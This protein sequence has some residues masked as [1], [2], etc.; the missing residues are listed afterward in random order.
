MNNMNKI[1]PKYIDVP[2]ICF[3]L[4]NKDNERDIEFAKQRMVRGFDDSETWSLY[5]TM[6][7]FII[8]RLKRYIELTENRIIQTEEDRIQ[9]NKLLTAMELIVRNDGIELFTKDEEKQVKEGVELLSKIFFNLW[10]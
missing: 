2:N 8:P 10:W 4:T 3:S 9:L 1:D 7:N 6:A 5:T